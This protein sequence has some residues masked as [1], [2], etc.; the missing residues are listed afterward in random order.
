MYIS[1]KSYTDIYLNLLIH[2]NVTCYNINICVIHII[3]YTIILVYILFIYGIT[4]YVSYI[5][6]LCYL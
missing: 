1:H 3:S 4:Y 5:I 2:D 6:K